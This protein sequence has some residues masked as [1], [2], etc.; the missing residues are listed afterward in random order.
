M[1]RVL[2]ANRGE[3]AV[4]VI[5]ACE[6]LGLETVAVYSEADRGALHTQLA[7]RAVC[8]GPAR[9]SESYLNVPALLTTALGTGCDAVHPGYGF[10]AENA[11][12]AEA[13]RAEGLT[14]V[15]PTAD[16]IA[17]MGD[18]A[19]AR[20]AVQQL[21]VPIVP[22]TTAAPGSA[23]EAIGAAEAIGYPILIKASA[24]GGGRGMRMVRAASEFAGAYERAAAEAQA[25]FGDGT[26]YLERFLEDIRHIEVQIV[27]DTSGIVRQLGERDCTAQRRHQ[28]LLEE[29][30]S[31]ALTPEMRSR[32]EE[33]AVRVGVAIDY[34]S[35]GTVE[36]VLDRPTGE[37]YFIEMN[38]RIQVEHPVTEMLTGVDLV[39]TQL[40][41]AAGKSIASI[42]ET[43]AVD[44]HA[45]ECRINAEDPEQGFRPSPGVISRW[46]APGGRDVRVDTHCFEGS[47]VSPHYDSLLAKVIVHGSS[48]DEAVELMRA[49]LDEFEIEG[50]ATTLPFHRRLMQDPQFVAADIN[51]RWVE[52]VF[53]VR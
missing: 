5:R 44:G 35:A 23:S 24:G 19:R 26:L 8:I 52:D 46:R 21:G 3:I 20:T 29:G 14:F 1:K 17:L 39:Q 28:K 31:P 12:F 38:T 48:R 16:V 40:L 30:P 2:V 51:T 47:V 50:I 25:A 18:K 13:S 15:G 6:S 22:G 37:F 41:V 33:A 7:D 53:L 34:V 32:I 43:P 11:G 27:G 10:L 42:P 49:A 36:F 9:A 45:I 4:R